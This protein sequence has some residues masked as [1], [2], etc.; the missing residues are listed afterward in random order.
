[1]A[2]AACGGW[3]LLSSS[4]PAFMVLYSKLGQ[5]RIFDNFLRGRIFNHITDNPG[6]SGTSMIV[7]L[8]IPQG[9]MFYHLR[10]LETEKCVWP[11]GWT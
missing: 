9:T 2:T 8:G 7:S 6:R 3:T 5:D 4:M 11:A 10:R 1:M